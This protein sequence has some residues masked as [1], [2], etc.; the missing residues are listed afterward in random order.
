VAGIE[1]DAPSQ[2]SA[3]LAVHMVAVLDAINRSGA[4]G[5]QVVVQTPA[6]SG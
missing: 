6:I 2:I 4:S 3:E 5:E 1:T